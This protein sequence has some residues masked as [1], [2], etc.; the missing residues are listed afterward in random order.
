[1]RIAPTSAGATPSALSRTH[2]LFTAQKNA[3]AITRISPRSKVQG[4]K[5]V[6]VGSTLDFGPW[7]LDL[8]ATSVVPAMIR[9][10]PA[11]TGGVIDSPTSSTA[12]MKVKRGK[13][14]IE[15]G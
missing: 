15:T 2:T 1:M 6:P 12:R 13:V 4:P 5:L 3:P 14:A 7:T 9:T 8:P 10:A 11:T